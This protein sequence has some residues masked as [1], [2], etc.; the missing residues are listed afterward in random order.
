MNDSE[1]LTMESE[2]SHDEQGFI[3]GEILFTIYENT[4]EHFS[5]AK[6]KIHDTNEDYEEKDIVAKGYFTNLQ[7]GVMYEFFGQL[8]THS[9]F[10]LQYQINSYQTFVPKTEEAV[11]AYLSSDLFYGIG[12]RTA[13]SIVNK[14]GENA[15]HKIIDHPDILFEIPHMKKKTVQSLVDTLQENQGFEKIAVQLTKYGV[16]LKMAQLLYKMYKEET[17]VFI[18]ENPYQFVYDI[19]GFGFLTADK[20]AELNGMDKTDEKRIRAS[21]IYVLQNSVLDGHVY[22]PIHECAEEMLAILAV[23]TIT[24]EL[25]I[26]NI[27]FLGE[28][29]KVIVVD[30]KVFLPSLY[31]AE[32]HFS[33]H[34][35][36]MMESEV[37]TET[38]DA[39]L[40]KIIGEI[41]EEEILSY[42]EEQFAAIKRA[43]HSKIM[44]LT[45]GPGTGKTTVIKGI[46]K[47]YA[48]IHDL[49]L[50]RHTYEKKA[51]YPFIL[52]APTGRAAKRL[53]ES[54]G[55]T[56]MTIHRLLGWDGNSSFDKNEYERLS[57]KLLIIDEFSM[58]DT[59]LANHLFKAIPTDMQV[60]LVGDEDQLPSVGPGQVLSDLL[61]S[62]LIPFVKLTEVYRQKEGSKIIQLAHQI[63][64][65]TCTEADLAKDTDFSFIP[66]YDYQIIDVVTTIFKRAQEKGLAINDIQVLAPMYRTEAGINAINK[67][68][69]QLVNPK[70]KSKRERVVNDV[71]FR[72]GDRILQLVN[73]PEDGVYN[74]DIG[75]V[76]QIFTAR[77]NEE[78][79]E[80]IVVA[81]EENE[82][83]YTRANYINIMHA[84]CISIHKSQGSEFPIV[85]LPVVRA[86][87]R[88]LRKNL[89]YTAITRSQKSLIMCG[90]VNAFMQG[91]ETLDTNKRYTTLKE[92]LRQKLASNV[93]ESQEMEEDDDLSPFDFM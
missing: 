53:H 70:S 82:V 1:V 24:E 20:M 85:V 71:I 27:Q 59:W 13:E 55:L 39:E 42:G 25:V 32:D 21:C 5:I 47:A 28:E 6:I 77:E 54:T 62:E 38:T 63:K 40:M 73:Q 75:E 49:S 93:T 60:L 36:R 41:E 8:E 64:K 26:D 48:D 17:I 56:A 35:K 4:A 33:S 18:R 15:I 83:V 65:D 29:K 67:H 68:V 78:K 88:M 57:G 90:E 43:I 10:G 50:D 9:K 86:Y 11:I 22:L 46:L 89:L 45:G 16:S 44:I 12:K 66:C 72:V 80:Q 91:I 52:T 37:K 7:K 30:G 58:V 19:E 76:V 51:D 34:M 3:K 31:Y 23:S 92:Q 61:S 84:Y 87:R 69:Q 74:G 14:L 81:F 2:K 79:Q